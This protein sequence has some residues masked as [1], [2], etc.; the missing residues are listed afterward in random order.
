[1]KKYI[2]ILTLL[3]RT[4]W[5]QSVY[6]GHFAID[7]DVSK[8]NDTGKMSITYTSAE[9][10]PVSQTCPVVNGKFHL[11]GFV[12]EPVVATLQIQPTNEHLASGTF[13]PKNRYRIL[14]EP[15]TYKLASDEKLNSA[16]VQGPQLQQQYATYMQELTKLHYTMQPVNMKAQALEKQLDMEGFTAV[17]KILDSLNELERKMVDSYVTAHPHSPVALFAVAEYNKP[18]M[19]P[20]PFK[21]Y[22]D[23]L[24]TSLQKTY[25][26][27]QL[28][29]KI[30]EM[31]AFSPG[32]YAANFTQPD[33]AGKNVQL[34]DFKGSY[35]FVDF[36]A[37]W[38]GPC[39]A[40]SMFIK[41]A[42]Q[43]FKDKKFTVLSVSLDD[44]KAKWLQAIEEDKVGM[45]TQ[46]GDM[47]GRTN[48]VAALYRIRA[49]P[50]NI[51]LDP[52]GKI[53]A[54]NLSGL[55]LEMTLDKIL[56]SN[57]AY[58]KKPTGNFP[59]I[60]AR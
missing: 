49:I 10:K 48:A 42:Y 53:I 9:G 51:L 39:R 52:T 31:A 12:E 58:G 25:T 3:C 19:S 24:D 36:W 15:A 13:D 1:M 20:K 30:E 54:K 26:G 18:V 59:N 35:V 28:A 4:G 47:T 55:Q 32:S 33:T 2:V 29:Q 40:Q 17:N 56:N 22:F 7:G 11:E 43:L 21:A 37:S 8:I 5:A 57:S 41:R 27:R 46:V 14:L 60:A 44:N 50:Q 38:C 34:S 16:Q 23:K 6:P 45:W